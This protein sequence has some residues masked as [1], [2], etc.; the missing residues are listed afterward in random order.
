MLNIKDRRSAARRESRLVC[1]DFWG[2]GGVVKK[3]GDSKTGTD[4][5]CCRFVTKTS[6]QSPQFCSL[7]PNMIQMLS[8]EM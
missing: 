6:N 4:G 2:V 7:N 8:N 5:T 1:E 3:V